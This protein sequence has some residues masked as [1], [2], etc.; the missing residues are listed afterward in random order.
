MNED[1]VA[2]LVRELLVEIGED[3]EREGLENTPLRVARAW[4]F[5]TSGY[6]LSVE[7]IINN[8]VFQAES[9]NMIISRDIEVYSLCEHHLL[10]FHGRCHIGYI[11]KTKV[12][13][14]SKLA[15]IVDFYGR[16]LQIQER[17][18][19]Q[20]AEEIMRATD[21]EGVGVVMEC[22][23]L[24]TMMRGVEKQNNIMTTSSV[25]GSFLEDSTTRQEFLHLIGRSI[26]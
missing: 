6:R 14:L 19:A 3:P 17:L 5:I 21:A 13:G 24:C 9:N 7:D 1:R 12:L 16:R 23:H 25:L 15:R 20:I 4:N 10:P 8:A 11:P 2:H 18:T 22:R 26:A